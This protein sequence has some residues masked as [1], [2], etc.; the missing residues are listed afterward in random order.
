MTEGQSVVTKIISGHTRLVP[1]LHEASC[2][3]GAYVVNIIHIVDIL[4]TE[5]FAGFGTGLMWPSCWQKLSIIILTH[6]S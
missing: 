5:Y 2:L 3:H 4:V 6:C 1:A